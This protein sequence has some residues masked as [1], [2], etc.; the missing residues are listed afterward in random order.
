MSVE[1][2]CTPLIILFASFGL[3]D[4]ERSLLGAGTNTGRYVA[5]TDSTVSSVQIHL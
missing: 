5:L 1:V 3:Q 2:F 4:Q